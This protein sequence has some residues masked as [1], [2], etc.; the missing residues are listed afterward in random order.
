M[1]E[2]MYE[3]ALGLMAAET[4]HYCIPVIHSV[5]VELVARTRQAQAIALM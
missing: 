3:L 4:G 2:L 5:P 1:L